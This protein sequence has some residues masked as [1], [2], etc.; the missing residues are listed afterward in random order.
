MR[1]PSPRMTT[2]ACA[3]HLADSSE[4]HKN[5]PRTV[6]RFRGDDGIG[7]VHLTES[8]L[9]G[10]CRDW[11]RLSPSA[12]PARSRRHLGD[13]RAL[14][15]QPVRR[16]VVLRCLARPGRPAIGEIAAADRRHLGRPGE[17]AKSLA[18]PRPRRKKPRLLLPKRLA[19]KP[20]CRQLAVT[21]VAARRRA[22]SRVNRILASLERP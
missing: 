17:I 1:G 7:W 20:G 16:G 6:L 19:T 21:P 5:F 3:I 15:P 18:T 12:G 14:L 2:V 13:A 10:R 9:I 22:S 4:G 11:F 8:A